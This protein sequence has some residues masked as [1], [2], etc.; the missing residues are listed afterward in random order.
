MVVKVRVTPGAKRESVTRATDGTFAVAVRERPKNNKANRRVQA[1][2]A[3]EF[4]V[5]AAEARIICGRRART[6]IISIE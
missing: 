2:I 5:A 4:G 3:R 1:L 6:K